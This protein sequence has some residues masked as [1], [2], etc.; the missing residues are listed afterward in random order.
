VTYSA[1]AYGSIGGKEIA[2]MPWVL[3][4]KPTGL[5][6]LTPLEPLKPLAPLK[7][8]EPL[9]PVKPLAPL[10]YEYVWVDD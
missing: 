7:P 2:S 6:P 10:G 4:Q 1:I 8:L 3:R 9:R 5:K